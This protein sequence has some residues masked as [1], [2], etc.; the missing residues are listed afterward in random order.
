MAH[1]AAIANRI[2][3]ASAPRMLPTLAPLRNP[4]SPWDAEYGW[5]R[6]YETKQEPAVLVPAA[7]GGHGLRFLV[8]PATASNVSAS[9]TAAYPSLSRRP[10]GPPEQSGDAAAAR[11]PP[12]YAYQQPTL[13]FGRGRPGV[14]HSYGPA[15]PPPTAASATGGSAAAY[16]LMSPYGYPHE[17]RRRYDMQPRRCG[18]W[19]TIAMAMQQDAEKR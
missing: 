5:H 9:A 13:P 7:V 14:A 6:A 11:A 3:D 4:I 1:S 12:P 15:Y 8:R 17:Q 16:P 19:M 2:A 18:T 10:Q